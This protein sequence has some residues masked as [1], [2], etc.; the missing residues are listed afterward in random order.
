M[1]KYPLKQEWGK[2]NTYYSVYN[3]DRKTIQNA[4]EKGY[5]TRKGTT[6]KN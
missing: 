1:K 2:W 4:L 5:Y 6:K 3:Q